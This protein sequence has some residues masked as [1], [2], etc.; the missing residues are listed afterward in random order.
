[1]GT[2]PLKALEPPLQY[3]SD[4]DIQYLILVI[5]QTKC[6][7][8][9]LTPY[10]KLYFSLPLAT[11]VLIGYPMGGILF[12]FVGEACPFIV[13]VVATSITWGKGSFNNYVDRF[14]DFLVHLPDLPTPRRQAK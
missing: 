11:G 9:L 12:D 8:F 10:L 5:K 1:M 4:R 3:L 14:L 2:R 13:I 6:A 7:L